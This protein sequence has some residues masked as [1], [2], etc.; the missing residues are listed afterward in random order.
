MA[1]VS[2]AGLIEDGKSSAKGGEIDDRRVGNDIAVGAGDGFEFCELIS[3]FISKE[4]L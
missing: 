2:N 3:G 1:E 4:T